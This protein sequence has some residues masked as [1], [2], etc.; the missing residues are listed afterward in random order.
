MAPSPDPRTNPYAPPTVD[1]PAPART[2]AT[3]RQNVL[4]T[5]LLSVVTLGIYPIYW[6]FRRARFLDSL[7][8]DKK[9]G[10]LPWL[11]L[12]GYVV[13]VGLAVA[14]VRDDQIRPIQLVVGVVNLV[15]AFRVARILRSDLARTGRFVGVSGPGVFF[16]GCLYLQHVI[17]EAAATPARTTAAAPSPPA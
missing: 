15:V 10:W 11:Y 4:L 3:E 16:F 17:N 12:A 2:Y 6:Y 14:R 13:V 1:S 9:L 5:L 8:S 7:A